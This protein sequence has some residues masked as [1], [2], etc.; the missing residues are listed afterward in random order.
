MGLVIG[1]D[2]RRVSEADRVVGT[3]QDERA[4][5]AVGKPAERVQDRAEEAGAAHGPRDPH[6]HAGRAARPHKRKMPDL[7]HGKGREND[8]Q[9]HVQAGNGGQ[10]YSKKH[11][12]LYRA[13][14][15]G[16]ARGH[17]LHAGR[18]DEVMEHLRQKR[19]FCSLYP[20]DVL[21][22]HDARGAARV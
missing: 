21:H 12:G 4:A 10:Y 7:L 3:V 11:R 8:P 2:P 9:G 19:L 6:A 14:E 15:D 16:G 13:A 20:L 1:G 17:A 5:E 22:G 18:A